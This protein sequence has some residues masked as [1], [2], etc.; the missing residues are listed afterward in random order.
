MHRSILIILPLKIS[1]LFA[2]CNI[3]SPLFTFPPKPFHLPA[4][5]PRFFIPKRILSSFRMNA[6][7]YSLTL[8]MLLNKL[9][10]KGSKYNRDTVMM[11]KRLYDCT[12]RKE[13]HKIDR[14]PPDPILEVSF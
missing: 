7:V 13:L 5:N 2:P 3:V 4:P 8:V 10:S 1:Y 12:W 14:N 6:K 9:I 11:Y